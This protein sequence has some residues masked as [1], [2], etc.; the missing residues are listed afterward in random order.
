MLYGRLFF[1][2]DGAGFALTAGSPV[3]EDIGLVPDSGL[4]VWVA[5]VVLVLE[6]AIP[7]TIFG[8]T[9]LNEKRTGT[10]PIPTPCG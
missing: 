10:D 3:V 1:L 7:P 5:L 4:S 8:W 2:M 6:L 9:F